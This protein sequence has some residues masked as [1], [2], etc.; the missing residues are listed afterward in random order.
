MD[1]RP[2]DVVRTGIC[3]FNKRLANGVHT[4][5]SKPVMRSLESSYQHLTLL[6]GVGYS[7][8][9]GSLLWLKNVEKMSVSTAPPRH[10]PKAV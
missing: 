4:T 10:I 1:L 2:R 5:I 3:S 9:K 6:C 8:H 7:Q